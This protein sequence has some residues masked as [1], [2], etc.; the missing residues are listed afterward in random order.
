[1]KK[2]VFFLV[3]AALT[4]FATVSN[5]YSLLVFKSGTIDGYYDYV[6]HSWN[7]SDDHILRCEDPGEEKCTVNHQSTCVSSTEANSIIASVTALIVG[8]TG[9]GSYTTSTGILV[10]WTSTSSGATISLSKTCN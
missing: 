4:T 6:S 3:L 5:A 10:S 1:M 8:G 2:T 7:T 9:S